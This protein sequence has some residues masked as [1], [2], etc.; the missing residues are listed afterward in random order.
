MTRELI[1]AEPMMVHKLGRKQGIWRAV[2]LLLI[3]QAV[4]AQATDVKKTGRASNHGFTNHATRKRKRKLVKKE[5]LQ[6]CL[7]PSSV[8]MWMESGVVV[9]REKAFF[10]DVGFFCA[11]APHVHAMSR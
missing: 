5:V 4:G 11:R 8:L 7:P 10:L 2:T 9:R 6:R 1:E 3:S